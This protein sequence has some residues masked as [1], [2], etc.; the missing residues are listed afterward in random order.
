M[1]RYRGQPVIIRQE[2]EKAISQLGWWVYVTNE[3]AQR[4]SLQQA[5]LAYWEQYTFDR[6]L[7]RLKGRPLS[8]TPMYVQRDDRATG[9]IPLLTIALRVLTLLEFVAR[10]SLAAEDVPLI[11][12]YAT[13]PKRATRRPTVERLLEAFQEITLTIIQE[14][15]QTLRHLTPLSELQQRILALLGFSPDIYARLCTHSAK[16]P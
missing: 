16:P 7:G 15:H 3:G 14:S 8:L 12:L 1:R 11:G 6:G 9:L 13:N 5:V 4:L 10:R 2:R